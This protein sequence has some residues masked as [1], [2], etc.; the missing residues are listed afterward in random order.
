[1]DN[2]QKVIDFLKFNSQS[3]Y[4]REYLLKTS[5]FE[6]IVHA[7][8]AVVADAVGVSPETVFKQFEAW[9]DGRNKNQE[10]AQ[11]RVILDFLSFDRVKAGQTEHVRRAIRHFGKKTKNKIHGFQN[12]GGGLTLVLQRGVQNEFLKVEVKSVK[13]VDG[14]HTDF[15]TSELAYDFF[16]NKP[17]GAG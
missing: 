14:S 6:Q 1:M 13:I 7:V 11:I 10:S 9:E 5:R 2:R 3:T 15:K 16:V 17:Q 8:F 4:I 12:G